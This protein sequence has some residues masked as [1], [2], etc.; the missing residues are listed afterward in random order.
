MRYLLL[1]LIISATFTCKKVQ[2]QRTLSCDR[3]IEIISTDTTISKHLGLANYI[4]EPIDSIIIV[5]LGK[6]I[7]RDCKTTVINGKNVLYYW[8]RMPFH[9]KPFSTRNYK[10]VTGKGVL[11]LNVR[12]TKNHD[13]SKVLYN[14]WQMNHNMVVR[15]ELKSD[16]T[17]I[18]GSLGVY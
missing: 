1:F 7:S 6:N 9:T 16:D 13:G 18:L 12:Q 17:Y 5:D 14:V 8:Y 2:A 15:F 10:L 4:Y 11:V 3:F